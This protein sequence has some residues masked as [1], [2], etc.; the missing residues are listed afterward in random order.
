MQCKKL[1]PKLNSIQVQQNMI[2]SHLV[3]NSQSKDIYRR[4]NEVLLGDC[5]RNSFVRKGKR[6]IFWFCFSWKINAISSTFF[7]DDRLCLLMMVHQKKNYLLFGVSAFGDES[8]G[9]A[10]ITQ[11][12]K[13]MECV[14]IVAEKEV[15]NTNLQEN[16]QQFWKYFFRT[17]FST[18]IWYNFFYIDANLLLLHI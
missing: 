3:F 13:M 7:F 14:I 9:I 2:G 12:M 4:K 16:V 1:I 15:V 6:L 5:V 10:E 8:K 17:Y 18:I 11:I